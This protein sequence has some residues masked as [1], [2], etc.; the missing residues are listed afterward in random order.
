MATSSKDRT[1]NVVYISYLK[2]VDDQTVLIADNYLHKTRD[3]LLT[4][5]KIT[6]VVHDEN[7]DSFQVE[8]CTKGLLE[9]ALLDEIQTCVPEI[10]PRVA[11]VIMHVEEIYNGAEWIS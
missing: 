6:F 2:V 9:G 4:N 5:G 1:P 7:K 11:A 8:G 3:N 10:L